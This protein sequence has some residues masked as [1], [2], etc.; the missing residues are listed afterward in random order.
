MKKTLV[1]LSLAVLSSAIAGGPLRADQPSPAETRLRETLKNT[2]LELRTAQNDLA[3]AQAAQAQD[4]QKIADL[5]ARNESLT[6]QA[7]A[8]KDAAG[9][10]IADLTA[11]NAE[12][13]K[14]I[15]EYKDAL[16]K[17]EAGY[18]YF[19][20]MA[21][22]K[23]DERAQLASEKIVLQRS[24]DDLQAKNNNLFQIGNEI[25]MR[26]QKFSL[27]EAISSKEPFVG[28]TRVRLENQV[29]NYRDKLLDGKNQPVAAGQTLPQAGSQSKPQSGAAPAS[30]TSQQGNKQ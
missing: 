1:I 10:A 22:A 8:D 7:I 28:L 27:G 14:E 18:T 11:K 15:A 5:T 30:Q 23:E 2:V 9:K 20:K 17:W 19:A 29:Q 12:Q 25:L 6:Q 13:A 24:A 3:T 4:E 21:K 26:Y 16:S